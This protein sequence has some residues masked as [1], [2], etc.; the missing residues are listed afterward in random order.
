TYD[1]ALW[2]SDDT[3]RVAGHTLPVDPNL[4]HPR[5]VHARISIHDL[6]GPYLPV[7]GWPVQVG[8]TGLGFSGRSGV[9]VTPG[10]A[11]HGLSY[12]L[13][14]AVAPDDAGLRAAVPNLA[15]DGIR[16]T[17]LPPGLPPELD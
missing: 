4:D 8:A 10:P 14:G 2:T 1:G 3:F 13:V 6:P 12:D 5:L 11:V 9:L 15:G 16:D 7:V 17:Q